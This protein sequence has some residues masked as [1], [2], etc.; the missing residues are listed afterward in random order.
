MPDVLVPRNTPRRC[1]PWRCTDRATDASKSSLPSP[2]NARRL[3]RQSN[4]ESA[5]GI[6]NSSTPSTRPIQ[7]ANSPA[8][9][10]SLRRSPVAPAR[11]LARTSRHPAPHAVVSVEAA[12][13][14]ITRH[15]RHGPH[16]HGGKDEA[17]DDADRDRD[18]DRVQ[19]GSVRKREHA[20][21]DQRRAA[22]DGERA[23][24]RRGIVAG[25]GRRHQ[26][27]VVHADADGEEQRDV[28]KDR[29][30]LEE[31]DEDRCGG[32]RCEHDGQQD[33]R[34]TRG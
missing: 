32:D 9:S 33:L 28:V 34:C 3:L 21:R 8:G 6:A 29:Q 2:I 12:I 16:E 17:R 25:D 4:R 14:I 7:V 1:A 19:H 27:R 26:Q 31:R 5:G 22:H 15:L 10:K 23:P 24:H 11:K 30:W 20:E 18:A 13:G